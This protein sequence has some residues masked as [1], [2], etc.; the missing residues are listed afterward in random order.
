MTFLY[1]TFFLSIIVLIIAAIV[2]GAFVIPLQVKEAGV[3]NGLGKLRKQLLLKGSLNFVM[4]LITIVILSLRYFIHDVE[5]LR[6]MT[7]SLVFLFSLSFLTHV[8][9]DYFVY[10]QNYTPENIKLHARFEVLEEKMAV[11]KRT[12]MDKKNTTAR[13]KRKLDKSEKKENN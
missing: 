7:T 2:A 10:R 6:Y 9:I 8:I 12:S 4:I 11:E 1:I 5:V 3:K 13:Q